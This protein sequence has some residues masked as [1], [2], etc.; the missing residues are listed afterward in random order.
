MVDFG[1]GALLHSG[2][3]EPRSPSESRS[4]LSKELSRDSKLRWRSFPRYFTYYYSDRE[5]GDKATDEVDKGL[6]FLTRPGAIARPWTARLDTIL[7]LVDFRKSSAARSFRKYSQR[8]AHQ[9]A[10]GEPLQLDD[11]W[12]YHVAWSANFNN[13]HSPYRVLRSSSENCRFPSCR[14]RSEPPLSRGRSFSERTV[15]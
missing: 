10:T 7:S 8:A 5:A 4:S 14:C 12:E 11:V 9:N 6:T 3:T 1:E 2:Q 13:V 15:S